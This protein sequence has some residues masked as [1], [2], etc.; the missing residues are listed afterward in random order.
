M[1]FA[2]VQVAQGDMLLARFALAD[3]QGAR[4]TFFHR[5]F[6]ACAQSVSTYIDLAEDAVHTGGSRDLQGI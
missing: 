4:D 1:L 3:D 6:Q 5:Q 2:A